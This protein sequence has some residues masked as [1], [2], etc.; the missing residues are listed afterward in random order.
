MFYLHVY[1]MGDGKRIGKIQIDEGPIVKVEKGAYYHLVPGKKHILNIYR[2]NKKKRPYIAWHVELDGRDNYKCGVDIPQYDNDPKHD[3]QARFS[4]ELDCLYRKRELSDWVHSAY[5]TSKD[6]NVERRI[7]ADRI[8]HDRRWKSVQNTIA[9]WSAI[10]KE[11]KFIPFRKPRLTF[12][13]P[14]G[15]ISLI[16][17]ILFIPEQFFPIGPVFLAISLISFIVH[18]LVNFHPLDR[19][20]YHKARKKMLE[21]NLFVD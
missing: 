21:Q 12:L 7:S 13:K 20:E 17:A 4:Y 14:I 9:R 18:F 19:I 1:V 10:R 15:W 5:G 3:V 16:P 2:M 8:E 6:P 11:G